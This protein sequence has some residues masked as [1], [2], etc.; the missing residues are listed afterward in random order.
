MKKKSSIILHSLFFVICSVLAVLFLYHI[1]SIRRLNVKYTPAMTE[2]SSRELDNP[3]RGFYQLSGYI[4]S[5]NQKPEKSAAWCRKSCASNPYPLMLL[6]INLKNYSNTSI[7]TNA[8]NQL[9][10]I[11]EECVRAKKQVI[12][13]FLY[14]W[15]GQALS[16]EPSDLP[17][18]KNHISQISST[19][20]KYA[21]C[22]YILQG[23]LTGNT[24]E[25]NHSNYGDINQIRQIIEEL[26]QNISSD[27]FLAVR[28]PGQLRG[29]LRTRTPLSV[30]MPAMAACR[31]DSVFLMTAC[32][33]LFMIWVLTMIPLYS[34]T[35]IWMSK[36]HE[37][38][39]FFSS[40]NSAN[41]FLMGVRLQ[42]IMNI[43]IWTMRLSTFHRC[44]YLT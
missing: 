11:L 6:E 15:D 20:N 25:M 34:R 17:Q 7:S 44:I 22:V 41:M 24:G 3:Y 21:D 38:R 2:E 27:I 42:L 16:T 1:I 14:D 10:K 35:V 28:T 43:T 29:I 9:D 30:Q 39:N 40:T 13:R 26:D 23:T 32:L 12:L 5:D 37:V 31:Q 33:V 36:A 8:K 4:L 19:V 18:I